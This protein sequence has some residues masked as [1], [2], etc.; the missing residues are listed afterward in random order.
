VRNVDL[1]M[2][3]RSRE[4]LLKQRDGK[5]GF[6]RK[7]RALHTWIE[8]RDCSNAYILWALLESGQKG[9]EK[10]VS[11]VK[12]SAEGSQ[13]SYVVALAANS[14]YLAGDRDGAKKQ[15]ERLVA[16]QGADGVIGGATASIV[17]SSGDT[18]NIETTSLAVLAWLRDPAYA[19]AVEKSLKYLADSCKNG[20]Y[21]STQS[22]VLA[23]RAI[24]AYDRARAH[25]KSP[26]SV[27]V[28]VDGQPVG[29]AL[30]FDPSTQ[31]A[32]KL[33]DISELLGKGAHEIALKM[34]DG[35]SMPYSIGVN[36]NALV[37]DSS[38]D[39]KLGLETRLAKNHVTE[40]EIVE[41][42]ATVTNRTG[43]TVPTPMAIVGL[44][45]GLEPRHDQLKEL[46][47]KHTIDAYEVIG[48]DVVLYWRGIEG[49]KKVRVP[50]SLVVAIPGTYTGPASRAYLYYS[51][52][53]K[54]WTDGL[55]VTI[56]PKG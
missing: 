25:P 43:E 37:P 44:P 28:Y 38:K 46:V 34:Q 29:S 8:D 47:K 9:L 56:A 53:H 48:R 40:G 6:E 55:K 22:T 12:S 54:T 13:N 33:P 35:G 16:K 14:L 51:D 45:G 7:R 18:L 49:G 41:V 20:R 2:V 15:M 10:E 52:E 26:G 17:G 24:V 19:G 27:R 23:L 31:G 30:A 21:G 50:L 11:A 39:C 36:Y 5:G 4:W 32:I 42:E 3:D 1:A